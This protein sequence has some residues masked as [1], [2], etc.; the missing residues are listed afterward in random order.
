V[1]PNEAKNTYLEVKTKNVMRN[2]VIFVVLK[3]FLF[4]FV[5]KKLKRSETKNLMQSKQREA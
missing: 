3:C 1:K 2:K 5:A 4:F